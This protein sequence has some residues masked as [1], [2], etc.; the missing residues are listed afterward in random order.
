M[1]QSVSLLT[2][3]VRASATLTAQRFVSPTGGLPT[4]GGNALGVARTD[5]AEGDLVPVDVIGTAVVEAG[6]AI[7]A[8]TAVEVDAQG[9]AVP[10]STG[11]TLGR[12][13]PEAVAAAA[14]DRVEVIL[15]AN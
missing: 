7:P 13:A 11:V 14:G 2:L 15:I 6:A 5:G 1:S 12:L 9:R 4:A 8:G 10:Q 3:S